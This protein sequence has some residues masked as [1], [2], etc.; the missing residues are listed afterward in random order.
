MSVIIYIKR[1]YVEHRHLTDIYT[2]VSI[3]LF[4]FF[5]FFHFSDA[6]CTF[7][8]KMNRLYFDNNEIDWIQRSF[9]RVASISNPRYSF[10]LPPSPSL[11][12]H[13]SR[14]FVKK[15]H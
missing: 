3:I 1:V 9:V 8:M 6:R 10:F 5:F 14:T 13:S 2:I 7:F 11:F 4:F 12:Y 15:I